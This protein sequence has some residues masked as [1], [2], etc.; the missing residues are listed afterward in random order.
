MVSSVQIKALD[1]TTIQ[2]YF[3]YVIESRINGNFQQAEKL[4]KKMSKD[5]KK[6]FMQYVDDNHS[7]QEDAIKVKMI[8]F[9][10]L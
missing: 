6:E 2:Q 10:L 1:F 7:K 3:E 8:A 4:I 9:K 5:Q